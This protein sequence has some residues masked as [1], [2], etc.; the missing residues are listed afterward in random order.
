MGK[1]LAVDIFHLISLFTAS[2]PTLLTSLS[3][4][5]NFLVNSLLN[6]TIY[7]FFLKK[8]VACPIIFSALPSRG[9]FFSPIT[10][11]YHNFFFP[12][13]AKKLYSRENDLVEKGIWING[14]MS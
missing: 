2:S 6:F 5:H 13:R 14:K 10:T 7:T 11:A 9:S 1:Y 8:D 4:I 12:A 3:L